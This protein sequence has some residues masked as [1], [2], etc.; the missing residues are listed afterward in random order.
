MVI[1]AISNAVS[2]VDGM[3]HSTRYSWLS[4][5][6]C[7]QNSYLF[8]FFFFLISPIAVIDALL[9]TRL[10]IGTAVLLSID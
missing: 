10:L 2:H 3:A 4:T 8:L 6:F 9:V 7:H 1:Q 5:P